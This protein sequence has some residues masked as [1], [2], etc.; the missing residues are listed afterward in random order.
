MVQKAVFG[1]PFSW[2]LCLL[3]KPLY[4]HFAIAQ[5]AANRNKRCGFALFLE[6]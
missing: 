1:P 5:K 3:A 2:A 4:E 6:F